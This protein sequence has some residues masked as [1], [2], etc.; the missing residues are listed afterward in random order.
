MGLGIAGHSPPKIQGFPCLAG[1]EGWLVKGREKG[2]FSSRMNWGGWRGMDGE[3]VYQMELEYGV[4][5]RV[6]GG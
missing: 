6:L 5:H 1:K 2:G 3:E 4:G